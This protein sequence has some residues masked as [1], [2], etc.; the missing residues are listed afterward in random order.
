M[1]QLGLDMTLPK[2]KIQLF[3]IK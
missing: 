1:V 2:G 3:I